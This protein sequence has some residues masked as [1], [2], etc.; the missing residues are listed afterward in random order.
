MPLKARNALKALREGNQRFVEG[1]SDYAS[2]DAE[3]KRQELTTGQE[4]LAVILGC[5]D[6]RVPAEIVFD[7]TLGDLF[8]IRVA[9]NIAAPSQIGSI[10]YAADLLGTRIVVVMGHTSCGAIVATLDQLRKPASG[11]SPNLNAIVERIAPVVDNLHEADSDD[12]VY[13]AVEANVRATVKTLYAESDILKRLV[14]ENGLL[15]IGAVY[16]LE[17]GTV[18]FLDDSAIFGSSL[19]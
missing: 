12:P 7:Q 2:L 1:K 19:E 4:P 17:T 6:S 18:T 14:D 9:G 10:E 8:V 11:I 13:D 16:S 15:L 3:A 5:S